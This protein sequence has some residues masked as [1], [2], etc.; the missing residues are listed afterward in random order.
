[1]SKHYYGTTGSLVDYYLVLFCLFLSTHDLAMILVLTVEEYT[2]RTRYVVRIV[3]VT[4]SKR[5]RRRMPP[6][7]AKEMTEEF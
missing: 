7:G 6:A 5:F 3:T 2:Y 1:M 4:T